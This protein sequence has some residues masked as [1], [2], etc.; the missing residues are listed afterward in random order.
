MLFKNDSRSEFIAFSD[1]IIMI[2]SYQLYVSQEAKN[3]FDD[4][5]GTDV[6]KETFQNLL[7]RSNGFTM[8]MNPSQSYGITRDALIKKNIDHFDVY[9]NYSDQSIIL[10][11]L[12]VNRVQMSLFFPWVFNYRQDELGLRDSTYKINL[13]DVSEHV[14]VY[15]ACPKTEIGLKLTAQINSLDSDFNKQ[16]KQIVKEWLLP[17][18]VEQYE[19]A[20][21]QY[22]P[23]K[24]NI[25]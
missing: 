23:D 20:Y 5:F 10:K 19:K 18:E 13:T 15:V 16:L 24:V 4:S 1:P 25:D 8:A 2:P 17:E 3:H 22:F 9:K 11:M 21:D 14:L 7:S 6:R 12:A